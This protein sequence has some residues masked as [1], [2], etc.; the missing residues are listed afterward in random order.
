MLTTSGKGKSQTSKTL[1]DALSASSHFGCSQSMCCRAEKESQPFLE[2]QV[3]QNTSKLMWLEM[4]CVNSRGRHLTD[5]DRLSYTFL[6]TFYSDFF[7]A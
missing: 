1:N 4:T 6:S 3:L 7:K 5:S 2:S